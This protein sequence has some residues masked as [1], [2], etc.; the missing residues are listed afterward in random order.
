MKHESHEELIL[1]GMNLLI[2][3]VYIRY[4]RVHLNPSRSFA[5]M[6]KVDKHRR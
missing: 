6:A 4:N 2:L 5:P 1:L 3:V